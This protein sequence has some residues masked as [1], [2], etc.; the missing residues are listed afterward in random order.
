MVPDYVGPRG[1]A[2]GENKDL[3]IGEILCRLRETR[4]LS[5]DELADI[6][7]FSASYLSLLERGKRPVTMHVLRPLAHW[8]GVT[9][10]LLLLQSMDPAALEPRQQRLVKEVQRQFHQALAASDFEALRRVSPE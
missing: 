3:G 7:G 2:T 5:Q 8:L 6:L 1:S 4:G 10:G 9:P